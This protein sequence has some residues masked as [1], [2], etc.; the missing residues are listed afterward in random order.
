MNFPHTPPAGSIACLRG[1]GRR[2]RTLAMA[3][4]LICLISCMSQTAWAQGAEAL[5]EEGVALLRTGDPSGALGLFDRAISADP[6]YLP[7]RVNR[8]IA[9][10]SLGRAQDALL[11]FEVVLD[12]DP[13]NTPAWMYRGDAF[14]SL[15]RTDDARE[16]YTRAAQLEPDNPLVKQRLANAGG[17]GLIPEIPVVPLLAIIGVAVAAA[18]LLGGGVYAFK[19]KGWSGN[20]VKEK[21]RKEKTGR[22]FQFF[23]W[24]RKPGVPKTQPPSAGQ[25][26][27]NPKNALSMAGQNG[28]RSIKGRITPLF[29]QEKNTARVLAPD[30]AGEQAGRSASAPLAMEGDEIFSSKTGNGSMGYRESAGQIIG[31]F[32]RL[33]AG[34][35]ISPSSFHGLSYY[36]MGNYR[37]A[38]R[39]FEEERSD[40]RGYPGITALEASTLMK[41]GRPKEAL[42]ACELAIKDQKGS[43]E[44]RTIQAELLAREGRWEE[45]LRACDEALALNPHSV[46]IWAM[47]ANALHGLGKDHEALQSCE[48][49]LG[50]DPSSPGL[51]RH[52]AAILLDLGR[53]DDALSTLDRGLSA[54][55]RDTTL[56]LEKGRILHRA[57]RDADALKEYDAAL[58]ISPD[59]P[60]AW[61]ALALV[62]HAMEEYREEAAAW[63][64][65]SAL[66]PG[67]TEY[68][69]AWGDA[70]ND[71]GD[72]TGSAKVYLSAIQKA[73]RDIQVWHRLGKSLYSAGKYRDA[74]KAFQ[75]ITKE[76][77]GDGPAWKFLGCSLV[78]AGRNEEA[79]TALRK[80]ES[81]IPGDPGIAEGIRRATAAISGRRVEAGRPV[82]S[83]DGDKAGSA[84]EEESDE[85]GKPGDLTIIGR[86][87]TTPGGLSGHSRSHLMK[88]AGDPSVKEQSGRHI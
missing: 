55:H 71:A 14:T 1:A 15:G 29:R 66:S 7:A 22:N 88:L 31:G 85:T 49:A 47:R 64:R 61:S 32:D 87:P 73:P 48:R 41:M 45:A 20:G 56:L 6:A 25:S 83:N 42:L 59:D 54:D 75:Y 43:F 36:A 57:G 10:L 63:E 78:E 30:P 86:D 27:A 44:M 58:A 76:S 77:P 53:V 67:I 19:R 69:V 11:S 4:L 33:L 80:G 35:G 84:T 38:L 9:L 50:M 68:L 79:L 16:S 24:L 52:K 12:R 60:R 28:K 40:E 5:T 8:G 39:A 65:A 18:L 74:V 3:V 26:H 37:D 17:G 62:L 34:T 46:D 2:L 81:I 82:R 51:L 13:G 72:F 21:V 70:L 23:S